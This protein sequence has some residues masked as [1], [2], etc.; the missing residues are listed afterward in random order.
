MIRQHLKRLQG[1]FSTIQSKVPRRLMNQQK[2]RESIF[3]KE[4]LNI[5]YNPLQ[6]LELMRLHSFTTFQESV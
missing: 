1:L 5:V 4:E 3:S 6:A 2:K